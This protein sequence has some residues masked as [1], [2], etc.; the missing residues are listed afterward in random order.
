MVQDLLWLSDLRNTSLWS[1][2][3]LLISR[4]AIEHMIYVVPHHAEILEYDQ[5][6]SIH[7]YIS[8]VQ[9][10]YLAQGF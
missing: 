1:I 6:V 10:I 3:A 4:Y 7:A 8:V 5:R 2:S 9:H